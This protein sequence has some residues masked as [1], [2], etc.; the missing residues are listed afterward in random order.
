[1]LAP[2]TF[3]E[4]IMPFRSLRNWPLSVRQVISRRNVDVSLIATGVIAALLVPVLITRYR[5]DLI[6]LASM[7][8]F[9]V[10]ILLAAFTQE[11][12]SYWALT[13]TS[14]VVVIFGPGKCKHS[15]RANARLELCDWSA[16]CFQLGTFRV[17]RDCWRRSVNDH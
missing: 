1:M 6:F 3:E 5:G 9:F 12:G 13:F 15:C 14:L 17:S 8:A 7:V 2:V 10:G 4:A 11:Q 16:H